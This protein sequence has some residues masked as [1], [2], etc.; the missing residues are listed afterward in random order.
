MASSAER[1]RRTLAKKLGVPANQ[2]TNQL[3]HGIIGLLS[4]RQARV[5]ELYYG[6]SAD[7]SGP[8]AMADVAA[9]MDIVPA[10]VDTILKRG[11][12]K[13]RE[14]AQGHWDLIRVAG[15]AGKD[16]ICILLKNHICT[17]DNLLRSTRSKLLALDGMRGIYITILEAVLREQRLEL[18]PDKQA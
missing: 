2:L 14:L 7:R 18:A 10:R 4:E 11:T 16:V 17:S 5:F 15:R 9:A 1:K 12:N 3:F 6:F 13:A 8:L